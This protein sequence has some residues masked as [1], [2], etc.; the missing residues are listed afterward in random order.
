M[1][2]KLIFLG[3]GTSQGV[4][5]IGCHCNVCASSDTRD[6]R[7]RASVYLEYQGVRLLIDAG[8]DFRQ[9]LLR[10]KIS[11]IDAILLTHQHIDHIAGLD[12]IRAFNYINNRAMDIYAEERVHHAIKGMY[13]YAFKDDKYPGIPEFAL[14]TIDQNPFTVRGV[15]IIPIRV[16][17]A[18]L[19]ILGFRIANLAYITDANY[20]DDSELT[21]LS[22]LSVLVINAVRQKPHISHFTLA[23]AIA[24]VQ[25]VGA[26][27]GFITHISHRM[28]LHKEVEKVL[29]KGV[30]FAYDGLEL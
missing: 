29:P 27:E 25:K 18:K 19:P 11:N 21:K 4:P 9:Q 24:I 28:G 12:D 6:Q 16:W 13:P 20:I 7:L 15:E 30:S 10:A 14:H 2:P 5:V 8:P 26:K 3:T 23:Q 17:H 22:D 1:I